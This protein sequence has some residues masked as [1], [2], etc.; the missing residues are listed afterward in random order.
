L[1]P[2]SL[3]VTYG[4]YLIR[5]YTETQARPVPHVEGSPEAQEQL[6]ARWTGFQ[7]AVNGDKRPSP[8][9]LSGEDANVFLSNFPATRDRLYL[10][11]VGDRLEGQFCFP[12]D[13]TRQPKLKGRHLNGVATFNLEFD[14]GLLTLNVA[15][16][17]ANNKPIPHWLLARLQNRNLLQQLD[18]NFELMQLFQKLDTIQVKDGAITLTPATAQ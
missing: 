17:E 9:R 7:A 5:T 8:L 6:K 10:R 18:A 11:I 1:G 13:Q 14:G 12:L 4:N 15:T 16:V 3:A 2:P